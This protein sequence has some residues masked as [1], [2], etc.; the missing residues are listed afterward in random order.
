MRKL[1]QVAP[2]RDADLGRKCLQEDS[3]KIA[4]KDHPQ[5]RIAILGAGLKVCGEVTRINIGD[6]SDNAGPRK[7]NTWRRLALRGEV[8]AVRA[9]VTVPSVVSA[10]ILHRRGAGSADCRS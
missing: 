3:K 7:G 8:N 4:G 10:P 1:W 2:R 9:A 5:Q 6:G